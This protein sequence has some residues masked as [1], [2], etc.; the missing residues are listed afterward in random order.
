MATYSV[1]QVEIFGQGV[2]QAEGVVIDKDGY[3]YGGG[4]NGIMYKVSPDGKVNEL[5]TLP[6]GSI[7]NGV[8]MD[9]NGDLIYCDLGKQAVMRVTQ[10]GKISMIADRVGDVKLTL[11]NFASY[12]AEGN[13]YVSNTSTRDINTVLPELSNPE[14][15]G[16]LV[17]IRPNGKGDVV[18]TGIYAANGTAID[19][20]EEAVYVLESSRN[21]CLRIAIKKDGSFGKAEVYSKEFPA[22]PDG[23][24]FDVDNNLYI[25]LPGFARNGTLAPANQIIKV[26]PQGQW[27]LLLDDPQ[28][29][30][31]ILPTNCAFGGPGLQD[32]Y[33]ANLEGSH[34][35][36]MH[37]PFRGHPLYH[38]R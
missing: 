18:A 29:T 19:P 3:V 17:R 35:S 2:L 31:L 24:A 20:Q 12:D 28:G 27:S 5:V 25:T 11:P 34:F 15:N 14:P 7:P 6:S 1:D 13:L 21:D 38:Q 32:L 33:F 30:K 16:A 37:T 23:M 9:R 26:D 10:S 22:L 8:A 4:R 36:R